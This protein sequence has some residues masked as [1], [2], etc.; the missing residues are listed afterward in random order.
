MKFFSIVVVFIVGSMYTAECAISA[1]TEPVISGA[2][3]NGAASTSLTESDSAGGTSITIAATNAV[4]YTIDSQTPSTGPTFTIANTGVISFTGSLDYETTTEYLLGITATEDASNTGSATVT[5]SITDANDNNP[6]FASSSR[7]IT[8]KN[9]AT[10][11][12]SL[13]TLTAT[14]ADATSAF[15]TISGYTISAGNTN[16]DFAVSNSGAITVANTLDNTVTAGYALTLQATD[17]TNTGTME[18][19]VVVKT[20]SSSAVAVISSLMMVVGAVLVTKL[21]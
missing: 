8:I 19:F 16:S 4:S 5:I 2:D 13:A 18:V 15:N 21:L 9:G 11:G 10:A 12:T 7:G 20:C 6:T 3:G 1:W 14:D 17:G